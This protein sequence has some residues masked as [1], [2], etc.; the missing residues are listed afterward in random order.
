MLLSAPGLP[1]ELWA[2]ALNTTVY[3]TNRSPTKAV[4]KDKTPHEMLHGTPPRYRHIKT[5]GCAAYALKPHAKEEGKMA[6]RSEKLWLIGYDAT[7]ICRVWD[8]VRRVV[9]T[10]RDVVFNE[11]ELAHMNSLP[12]RRMK[13][14]LRGQVLAV[15]HRQRPCQRAIKISCYDEEDPPLPQAHFAQ[16][17]HDNQTMR[18]NHRTEKR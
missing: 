5:F 10:S 2:E 7:T 13:D 17:T 14:L 16:S 11:T 4:P 3:L 1:K 15:R 18:I 9:R 12:T 6:A 8:P